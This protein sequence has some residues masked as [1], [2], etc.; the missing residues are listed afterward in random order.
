MLL[1]VALPVVSLAWLLGAAAGVA[2]AAGFD[3]DVLPILAERCTQCHGAQVRM[4]G[5][6]LDAAASVLKGSDNGAVI[7]PGKPDESL[8]VQRIEA[9]TMPPG[10]GPKLDKAQIE[11]VR[12]WIAA[13]QPEAAA[14]A[15]SQPA[16]YVSS[17]T[18][19]DR[20]FWSF[21][22]LQAV[23]PPAR[24]EPGLSPVDAFLLRK[25]EQQGL[26]YSPAASRAR[27][28]RRA[29][30]DLTG[31]PPT[32]AEIEAFENDAEPGAYERVIDR[33]L[34]S[35]QFGER[36]GRHWLDI[37]GYVD[38]IGRD[39]Q[40]NGYKVGPGRWRYRDYVVAAFN[41]DKPFDRFLQEQLAGDELVRWRDAAEY[42][43]QTVEALT[44]TGYLRTVE[45]PTDA[46]E[47]NTALLQYSVIHQ[48]IE[49]MT[50]GITGLTVG[51]ARCHTH[52]FDPIPQRDYYRLMAVLA[53]AYN[54]DEWIQPQDRVLAD[55]PP[56][57]RQA[58]DEHNS[59]ID[60]KIEPLSK[61]QAEI[62]KRGEEAYTDARLAETPAADRA[63]LEGAVRTPAKKRT[64]AQ[65][66]LAK[67]SGLDKIA[68]KD[69]LAALSAEERAGYDDL[70]GR[71]GA[72][73]AGKRSYHKLEA[74]YDAGPEPVIHI[75]RRGDFE[76][77][78]DVAPPGGLEVL[79]DPSSPALAGA[80]ESGPRLALARWL[81]SPETR[82]G[83]LVARVE[84]NRI[85]S[86]LFGE[87]IVAT[88]D[89]FGKMGDRPSH[90][91]LLEWLAGDFQRS[92]W[93]VK[94]MIRQLMLTQAYR[95]DST[96]A[97]GAAHAAAAD[98]VE[99]DPDNRL[100]WRMRTRRLE[101]EVIR[102]SMLAVSG[103][104]DPSVGG[105]PIPTRVESDGM[106]VFDDAK[107]GSPQ[108]RYRR[109][110]Y[111]VARRRFNLSML[112]VFDHPVMSTNATQRNASAVVLQS[113]MMLNDA[114]VNEQAELFARRVKAAGHTPADQIRLAFRMAFG[115][116]P[117]AEELDWALAF[118]NR[119]RDRY[120]TA[121]N[122]A[123]AASPSEAALAGVCHVLFNS[124]EFLYVE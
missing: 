58:I 68:L 11:A 113:L 38:T 1:R 57:E 121:S 62:V 116:Y 79:E 39:V 27:L 45:D 9:G 29:T 35:P 107:L 93:R 15:A 18:E 77:P 100:L 103:A 54:P 8:L 17:I 70:E 123:S 49:I 122:P 28:I 84:V 66:E 72:L 81:T 115:R 64:D 105:P 14:S 30:L 98:P 51:C 25:L 119:E 101:S 2:D 43:P 74:L 75:H 26:T 6:G 16:E 83:A 4:A 20:N 87:G 47:R 73:N 96:R 76:M 36:W 65:K 91:E 71:I 110:L 124:N 13:V 95:Q 22:P 120:Q 106:V 118:Y 48:T 3:E 114:E 89:N 69:A 19:E 88:L 32:P 46:E 86:H 21:R 63:A 112:G 117:A 97:E 61:Q 90:P 50:S 31:L 44:A 59:A 55:V 37:A 85:W 52:K 82:A 10:D 104:L 99:V 7:Q 41:K 40:A 12:A 108:S 67:Q 34:A 102:D 111:L 56:A 42:D 60:K 33:L 23:Q 94:P 80:S 24:P 5:L 109:S 92:G 78:G 53:T